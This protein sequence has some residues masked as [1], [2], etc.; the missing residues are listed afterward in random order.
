[1]E[2]IELAIKKFLDKWATNEFIRGQ[3]DIDLH[4]FM[5][6]VMRTHSEIIDPEAFTPERKN[7]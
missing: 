1:M 4:F 3:M 7:L 6:T 5:R 2:T